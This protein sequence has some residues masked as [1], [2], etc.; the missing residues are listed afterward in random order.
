MRIRS[1][2]ACCWFCVSL[3]PQGAIRADSGLQRAVIDPDRCIECGVCVDSLACPGSAFEETT[4][5]VSL[6]KKGFGRMIAPTDDKVKVTGRVPTLD[7]KY[8]DAKGGLPSATTSIRLELGRPLGCVRLGQAEGV[9]L[10]LLGQG[11]PVTSLSSYSS[12]LQ[13]EPPRLPEELAGILV[14]SV[15]LECVLAPSQLPAFLDAAEKAVQSRKVCTAVNLLLNP[16]LEGAVKQSL[17]TVSRPIQSNRKAN[18]GLAAAW[19]EQR[20]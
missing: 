19:K 6:I 20:P 3:C 1:T 18:L 4:D 11:F 12:L 16:V 13:G 9:R 2:C 17:A 10:E 7:V 15:V 8:C 14:L 5:P